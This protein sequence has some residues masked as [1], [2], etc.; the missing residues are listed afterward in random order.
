[1]K[2]DRTHQT[3]RLGVSAGNKACGFVIS[4]VI[5]GE[6]SLW[7]PK[8][9]EEVTN[10]CHYARQLSHGMAKERIGKVIYTSRVLA[11]NT[12]HASRHHVQQFSREWQETSHNPHVPYMYIYSTESKNQVHNQ[13]RIALR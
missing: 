6:A 9:P 5:L 7:I 11:K 10:D 12:I 8:V 2:Q 4:S 13:S 3:K 1:M